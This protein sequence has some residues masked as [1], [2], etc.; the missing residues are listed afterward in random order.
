VVMAHVVTFCIPSIMN[1]HITQWH[2]NVRWQ[3]F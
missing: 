3:T 1:I 2:S